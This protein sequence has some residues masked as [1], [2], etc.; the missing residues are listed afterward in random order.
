[1]SSI[2]LLQYQQWGRQIFPPPWHSHTWNKCIDKA[3]SIHCFQA[4]NSM[5]LHTLSLTLH[6]IP[7]TLQTL[8]YTIM[9]QFQFLQLTTNTTSIFS[10]NNFYVAEAELQK[11]KNTNASTI[12]LQHISTYKYKHP[13]QSTLSTHMSQFLNFHIFPC[14]SISIVPFRI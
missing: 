11:V 9:M 6:Y 12:I 2:A 10:Y 5:L 3:Y 13:W 4:M 7:S 14:Q 8:N 1:M